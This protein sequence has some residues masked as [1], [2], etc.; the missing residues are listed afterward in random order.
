MAKTQRDSVFPRAGLVTLALLALCDVALMLVKAMQWLV[1]ALKIV[2]ALIVCACQIVWIGARAC[3][4][5]F[6]GEMSV[7]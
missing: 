6:T 7:R 2:A 5:R 4:M 1:I 3:W